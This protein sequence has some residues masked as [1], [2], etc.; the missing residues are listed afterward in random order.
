MFLDRSELR[1]LPPGG[2]SGFFCSIL[3]L[4]GVCCEGEDPQGNRC[5][6]CPDGSDNC[7]DGLDNYDECDDPNFEYD[8]KNAANTLPTSSPS[9]QIPI[10]SGTMYLNENHILLYYHVDPASAGICFP[11]E[12]DPPSHQSGFDYGSLLTMSTVHPMSQ[13]WIDTSSLSLS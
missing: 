2:G 11:Y 5:A 3:G 9:A 7:C 12:C 1:R 10:K 4:P 8:C 13:I 6:P